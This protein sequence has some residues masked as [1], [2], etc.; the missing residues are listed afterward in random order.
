MCV[1][2][3]VVSGAAFCDPRACGVGLVCVLCASCVSVLW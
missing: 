1:G 3:G 2:V